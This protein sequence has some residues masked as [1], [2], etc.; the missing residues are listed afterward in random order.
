MP[1]QNDN[2]Q[3]R[4]IDIPKA[5]FRL[6]RRQYPARERLVNGQYPL[7]QV[8]TIP[9]NRESFTDS[10]TKHRDHRADRYVLVGDVGKHLRYLLRLQHGLFLRRPARPVQFGNQ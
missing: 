10:Q 1:G 2:Q 6:R 9:L 8:Q 5:G 4:E 3:F 7:I